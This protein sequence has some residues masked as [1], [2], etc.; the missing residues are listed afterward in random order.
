MNADAAIMSFL[1][2]VPSS[3]GSSAPSAR[4]QSPNWIDRVV[5]V[6]WLYWRSSAVFLL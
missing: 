4:N 3:D 5:E 6:N 1:I 2:C